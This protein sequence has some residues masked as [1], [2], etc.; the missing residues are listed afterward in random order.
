MWVSLGLRDS[1]YGI[2]IVARGD[3]RLAR[4]LDSLI[5]MVVRV[6][7]S[8]KFMRLRNGKRQSVTW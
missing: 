4:E 6:Y 1:A 8:A 3:S 2:A 7:T 5:V